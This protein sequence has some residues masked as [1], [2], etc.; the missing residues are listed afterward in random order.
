MKYDV[1]KFMFKNIGFLL[2]ALVSALYIVKGLYTLGE[3]GKTVAQI[4]GDGALSASVGFI[5]GHLM[6]Q[7]GINYGN[8]DIEVVKTK[9]FHSMLLDTVAPHIDKLDDFCKEESDTTLKTIRTRI[10]SGGGLSY[11]ECFYPDGTVRLLHIEI[12]KGISKSE[13]KLLKAKRKALKKALKVKITP[14]S[15]EALSVDGANHLDPYDF[16]KTQ[17]QYLSKKSGSDLTNKI[18]FGFLFGYYAIYLTENASL[19]A[20]VWASLQ[21]AIYLIFGAAQMMQAYLFV[22][23]ECNARI[24][25]KIDTL[26]KLLR[27]IGVKNADTL[28]KI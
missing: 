4:I 28:A 1:R 12:P 13:R 23:N 20:V 17:S 3:S 21:I 8:D 25:R 2:V 6:R 10:L 7:T 18:L 27:K 16:G 9:S 5:I 22:K 11:E 24:T 14:L 15:A 19:D 26:Q